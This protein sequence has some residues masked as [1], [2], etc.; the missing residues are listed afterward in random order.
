MPLDPTHL[1][2]DY[3]TFSSW[4]QASDKQFASKGLWLNRGCTL[5]TGAKSYACVHI[6][7]GFF[8]VFH[9]SQVRYLKEPQRSR[10]ILLGRFLGFCDWVGYRRHDGGGIRQLQGESIHGSIKDLVYRSFLYR[11]RTT[12]IRVPIA[13]KIEEADKQEFIADAFYVRAG[14][15]TKFFVLDLDNHRPT[16]ESTEAHLLLVRRLVE[17]LPEL[18]KEV[19]GGKVFYDY[20]QFAPQGIHIWILLKNQKYTKNLHETVRKFLVTHSDRTLDEKLRMSGLL[21]MG[22]IEILPT[23]SHLIR[24]FGAYDRTVFTTTELKP[25]DQAFD[26][27]ALLRHIQD[28]TTIGDPCDRYGELARAG[29]VDRRERLIPTTARISP[30]QSILLS[31]RP[32]SKANPF[33][34]LVD[35]CLNGVSKPDVLFGTYLRPLATALY[36]RDLH[37]HPHRDREV[38]TTLMRW[39][40]TKHNGLVTRID[41]GETKNLRGII[42]RIVKSIANAPDKVR[43]FWASV[44]T[45]DLAHPERRVSLLKCMTTRLD[46][47]FPVRKENLDQVRRLVEGRDARPPASS[48]VPLI[49]PGTVEERLRDHLRSAEVAPGKCSDRI[50][51]FAEN[52]IGEIGLAGHRRIHG[53]RIN[54]LAGLGRGRENSGRYKRLLAG[55]GILEPGWDRSLKVGVN[56]CEYKLC[57]WVLDELT[58]SPLTSP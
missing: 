55:A 41:N 42:R 21:E 27:Q 38:V 17:L 43:R 36:L 12:G 20:S 46:K 10:R 28:K 30:E 26:A 11:N 40:E 18:L 2:H 16:Q 1:L 58:R 3:Q 23:E 24:F 7:D 49:L 48:P 47:P 44:R 34:M 14:S 56:S 8:K 39:L 6:E 4:S 32:T 35:A 25:R 57:D 51:R 50:V 19:G 5:K 9:R 15:L 45:K 13:F 33:V 52:L 29:L 22:S 54:K 53:D 31:E 37:D